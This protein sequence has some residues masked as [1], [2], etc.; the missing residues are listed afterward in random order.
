MGSD[1]GVSI[2]YKGK[3]MR[4][5]KCIYVC[6]SVLLS[7]CLLDCVRSFAEHERRLLTSSQAL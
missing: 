5:T 3:R 6:V 2:C 4:W 1:W 7:V